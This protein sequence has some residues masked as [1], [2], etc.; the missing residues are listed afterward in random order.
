MGRYLSD[1]KAYF[2]AAL[3][4]ISIFFLLLEHDGVSWWSYDRTAIS[5]GQLWR[6]FTSH[7]IHAGANHLVL[8]M[9]GLMIVFLFFGHLYTGHRWLLN[10]TVCMAGV[11][12][13]LFFLNPRIE[14]YV[15]MSGVLHGLMIIG[16]VAAI[17]SKWRFG[18][19]CLFVVS[20]KLAFEQLNGPSPDTM[21]F[22]GMPVI[23]DSHLYGAVV[24]LLLSL[25]YSLGT[26]FGK[27]VRW[28]PNI[29]NLAG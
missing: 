1:K 2:P 11:S 15:G 17:N 27:P 20:L 29:G 21:N 28:F 4:C 16:A 26:F 7:L 24:G 8:N 19:L 12:L 10:L 22:I 25:F 6:L 14:W 13:G 18:Y 5:S 3:I 23:A 9:A